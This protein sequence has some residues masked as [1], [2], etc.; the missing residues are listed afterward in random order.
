MLNEER[1]ELEYAQPLDIN[2][3]IDDPAFDQYIAN[4]LTRLC[5]KSIKLSKLKN[6]TI[7][8]HLKI[9]LLNLW[10]VWLQDKKKYLFV[11]RDKFFYSTLLKQYNPNSFSY[12]NVVVMDA[13]VESKFIEIKI[14]QYRA[15]LKRRTR[16]RATPKLIK[17]IVKKCK[18]KPTAIQ[19]ARNAECIIL[20]EKD[21]D[22]PKKKIDVKYEENKRIIEMRNNLIVYNNLLR[23]THIDIP[24]FSIAG[25]KQSSGLS[26]K[27]NFEDDTGK[28]TRRIFSNKSWKDGGRFYGGW[29]QQVPNRKVSW[30]NEIR[31]NNK[32]TTEIDYSGIHIVFLYAKKKID[33][34]KEIA[35]DP[36]DLTEYG[37]V[38]DKKLRN[39]LKVVLLT[40]IN[41]EKGKKRDL[42]KAKQSVQ[43]A[44]NVKQA[45]EFAWVKKENLDIEKLIE[46][47]ADYHKP[48]RQYFYSGKGISLQYIDSMVAEKL[49][50]HFTK[51]NIPILCIH[52]SFIIQ[53]QFAV[54]DGENSLEFMMWC[55]FQEV[56]RKE[57]KIYAFGQLKSDA[58]L[59]A[60]D[61]VKNQSKIKSQYW[62]RVK[63]H[64][65]RKFV[66]NWYS[67][68]K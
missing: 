28:F 55:Y 8:R 26:F 37:Y 61:I 47:F 53:S 64:N 36:Y 68:D 19:I 23:R 38:M 13:L 50:N 18:I 15:K 33:Y 54:G 57:N 43:Y 48:I 10:C 42:T 39:L 63:R 30:R 32:P 21:A 14:G 46:D 4:L 1:K 9:M 51:L 59:S 5:K 35:K 20:R 31:I 60:R 49:I 3:W 67:T 65:K 6:S 25:V 12:K 17:E 52:D 62:T 66:I 44:I 11:S 34:W 24:T 22:D 58:P 7:T 45:D 41:C 56:I 29:W 40:S 2:F 16:I 27:I